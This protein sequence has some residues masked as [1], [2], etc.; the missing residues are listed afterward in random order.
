MRPARGWW[1][2]FSIL[3]FAAATSHAATVRSV[4]GNCEVEVP[5]SLENVSV[6]WTGA[7]PEGKADGQGDL[8]AEDLKVSGKFQKG[9]AR[10]ASGVVIT[11]PPDGTQEVLRV[12]VAQGKW[13]T[14]F[15]SETAARI[16]MPDTL[17]GN[18]L[19]NNGSDTCSEFLDFKAPNG[20]VSKSDQG[21]W[22]YL[23]EFYPVKGQPD[24]IEMWRVTSEWN[25]VKGCAGRPP[26][27]LYN[28]RVEYLRR[29][30]DGNWSFC[31]KPADGA[32]A[33]SAS[34]YILT[35]GKSRGFGSGTGAVGAQVP[36]GSEAELEIVFDRN[37]GALY[38]L[39]ARA[40]RTNPKLKGKVVFQFSIN[41]AGETHDC[42][43]VSSELHDPDLEKK[44]CAR[45]N[46]IRYKPQPA[47]KTVVKPVDFF[48]AA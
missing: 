20:L 33:V 48:P 21:R 8:I 34:R 37:K 46:L 15:L 28:L 26:D 6:R 22:R 39:Y 27:D 18:W 19:L 36:A 45:I 25:A 35:S 12:T 17:R 41:T 43:I 23:V 44:M 5:D 31:T 47:P 40:L 32:C 16:P 14:R 3:G 38:A 10:E 4:N 7:C 1:A 11:R 42:K 29:K 24:W 2:A 9:V 13:R 30:P